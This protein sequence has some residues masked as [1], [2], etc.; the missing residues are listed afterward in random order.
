MAFWESLAPVRVWTRE[1]V[2]IEGSIGKPLLNADGKLP[3]VHLGCRVVSLLN[4]F[5]PQRLL[6]ARPVANVRWDVPWLVATQ[7]SEC[8]LPAWTTC[9]HTS[10]WHMMHE[11]HLLSK[12]RVCGGC[13][14][15]T[16][17]ATAKS[18]E[19]LKAYVHAGWRSY[20]VQNHINAQSRA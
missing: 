17:W 11:D 2:S 3:G 9:F 10:L 13:R 6:W 1:I 18:R 20:G 15:R 7:S 14:I 19:A 16:G 5:E 4:H 8:E 12:R